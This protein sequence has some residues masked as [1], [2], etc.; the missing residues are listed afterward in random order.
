MEK[1]SLP[2]EVNG[3]VELEAMFDTGT[4]ID[5]INNGTLKTRKIQAEN[6]KQ[7]NTNKA[8]YTPCSITIRGAGGTKLKVLEKC[9]LP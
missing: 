8:K 1:P 7:G 3:L 4:H 5:L 6:E 9:F 2:C